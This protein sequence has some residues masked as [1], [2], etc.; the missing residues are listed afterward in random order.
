VSPPLGLQLLWTLAGT[1]VGFC[2]TIYANSGYRLPM[3]LGI[4]LG[5]L[6]VVMGSGIGRADEFDRRRAQQLAEDLQ[7]PSADM[8]VSNAEFEHLVRVVWPDDASEIKSTLLTALS[9]FI[10]T[11][12][13]S[14]KAYLAFEAYFALGGKSSMLLERF[15]ESRFF[16]HYWGD[17]GF[18]LG[19]PTSPY[20]PVA[21]FTAGL[22]GSF[23]ET[24]I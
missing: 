9:S 13:R 15:F 10:G 2:L 3:K 7:R 19:V 14:Y 24:A 5:V 6:L 20:N 22:S 12:S 1:S 17:S 11:H 23:G 8:I 16:F 21:G 18:N 4:L